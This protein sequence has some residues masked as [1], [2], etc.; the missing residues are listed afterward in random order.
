MNKLQTL[1][2]SRKH[3]QEMI[4]DFEEQ[5][6]YTRQ[7][8]DF[9]KTEEQATQLKARINELK[10]WLSETESELAKIN[11]QIENLNSNKGEESIMTKQS[12]ELKTVVELKEMAKNIGV[13]ITSKM[14]KADIIEAICAAETTTI[15]PTIVGNK[16]VVDIVEGQ[17]TVTDKTTGEIHNADNGEGLQNLMSLVDSLKVEV[18]DVTAKYENSVTWFKNN[19]GKDTTGQYV[20]INHKAPQTTEPKHNED[21]NTIKE[22]FEYKGGID[23]NKVKVDKSKLPTSSLLDS[24]GTKGIDPW[25]GREVSDITIDYLRRNQHKIPAPLQGI[26][27]DYENQKNIRCGKAFVSRK[28]VADRRRRGIFAAQQKAQTEAT[29]SVTQVEDNQP[30]Y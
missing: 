16:Y 23:Y 6:R 27:I 9:A 14:R 25:S 20:M 11:T 29:K 8:L 10:E 4:K 3:S 17:T 5:I 13:T 21:T 22:A 19:I 24:C 18:I 30:A 28:D 26:C 15:E 7:E 1:E 2:V 12:I